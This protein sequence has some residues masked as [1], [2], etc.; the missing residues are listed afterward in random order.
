MNKKRYDKLISFTTVLLMVVFHTMLFAWIWY[1]AYRPLLPIPYFRRGNYVLILLYTV[2]LLASNQVFGGLRLGYYKVLDSIVGRT[3]S[4]LTSYGA[5][6]LVVSL[7]SYR[8]VPPTHMLYVIAIGFLFN[9]LWTWF[10]NMIYYRINPPRQMLLIHGDRDFDEVYNK[11][12]SRSE[13][14]EI[15]KRIHCNAGEEK[16]KQV[17]AKHEAVI[18]HDLS[19]TLRNHLIK[20]CYENSIRVYVTPKLYDILIRGASDMDLFDTPFLLMRNR[21]LTGWQA[22]VKRCMDLLI[23]IICLLIT[24]PVMLLII[25]LMKIFDKGPVFYHQTRLT[26]NGKKFE[27]LKFRSMRVDAEKDTI[28]LQSQGDD[29][30]TPLGKILRRTHLDELPQLFNIIKGDMSFVGPRP[31]RPEIAELYMTE[32]PEFSYRLKMKAG[33]TGYAQVYGKYNS[34]PY[35]KLKLDLNYIQNYSVF[36]DIKLLLLTGKTL[37]IPDHAEGVS[38]AFT[39]ALRSETAATKIKKEK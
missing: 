20:Y 4:L 38:S 33:L 39:T 30:I 16:L 2:F 34:S 8:L 5:M 25:L 37:F 13:K 22:F 18:L 12:S 35:D 29:R 15:V 19:A 32:I 23:S 28:R 11:I 31:E 9:I 6:Y 1:T 36:L 26:L 10:S 3:F 14:Y 21:G 17:M 27:I 7:V 24:W